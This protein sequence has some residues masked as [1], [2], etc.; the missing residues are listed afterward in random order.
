MIVT[1]AMKMDRFLGYRSR[2]AIVL[3]WKSFDYNFG[4][5]K[6]ANVV[7]K[8]L[9]KRTIPT[10]VAQESI[11]LYQLETLSIKVLVHVRNDISFIVIIFGG[12]WH[13]NFLRSEG[14]YTGEWFTLKKICF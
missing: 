7:I 2:M 3:F 4:K 1:A 5:K 11:Q 14:C 13:Y 10:A 8:T 6:I 12:G 9:Q